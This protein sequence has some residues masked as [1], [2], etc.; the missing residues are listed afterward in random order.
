MDNVN[1]EIP[2]V[3][4]QPSTKTAN[5][6]SFFRF[7]AYGFVAVSIGVSIA[8]G[9]YLLGANKSKFQPVAQVSV[10]PSVSPALDPTASW[11]IYANAQ[12]GIEFRYPLTFLQVN[13]SKSI[14]A[15]TDTAN[16][17]QRLSTS[18]DISFRVISIAPADDYKAT[19][20]KDVVSSGS[21]SHPKSFAEFS[22]K[23]F[24]DK[25]VYFI[26]T[27]LLEGVL[28]INYYL[29][30]KDKIFAFNLIS[31]PVD[32]ANPNFKPEEDRL[33]LELQQ[34]LS[35]FKFTGQA[36]QVTPTSD[37]IASL[38]TYQNNFF[39]FTFKYPVEWELSETNVENKSSSIV[40]GDPKTELA[41][42]VNGSKLYGNKITI[43]A[44]NNLNNYSIEDWI[45]V[46]NSN[47]VGASFIRRSNFV[48]GGV[49]AQRGDFGCCMTYMDTLFFGRGNFL[50]E[51]MGGN[52][53]VSRNNHYA[54]EDIFQ[55]ML[56]TFK[57][58]N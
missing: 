31:G 24:G 3:Q 35:T 12:Y 14:V 15:F 9:G 37:P 1:Q 21:G 57:F 4:S 36:A 41:G 54:Y 32:W 28:S 49:S 23:T 44:I 30:N 47:P 16:K 40:I 53:G 46:K 58:T 29:V 20:I 10:T 22:L 45:K 18:P 27:G 55:Q 8:V 5:N 6:L 7:I 50:F 33:N 2:P 52:L 13:N 25:T 26:K 39:G 42:S 48:I 19:L 34:V 38:K 43:E 56:S 51:I 11:K 17:Q